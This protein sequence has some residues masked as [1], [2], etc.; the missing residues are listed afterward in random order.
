[1][2]RINILGVQVNAQRFADAVATLDQWASEPDKRYICTCPVYTLMACGEDSAVRD[3][4]NGAAMVTADGMP[5]VWVQRRWGCRDA[6]RVYGPDVMLALCERTAG[7]GARHFFY[8]GLPGVADQLAC[9]LQARFP[10]LEIAGTYT[11]PVIAIDQPPDL[12]HIARL[13]DARADIIWVGLGSPKQDLWMARYRP[14]LNAPLLIGVGAAFDFLAG[15]KQQAPRWMQ[16]SGLEWAFRLIQEPQ[17]L[18]RRYL[19][20]NPRFIW[21]VLMQDF[22]RTREKNNL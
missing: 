16:R 13:N 18:W 22:N 1:M 17:R 21:G 7:R 8:G 19:I 10:T 11:P 14:L 20:Y 5:V 3:A 6:E 12:S 9:T 4:V 2:S 15:S